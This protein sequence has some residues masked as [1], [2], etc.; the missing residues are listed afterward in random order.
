MI[1]YSAKTL[2]LTLKYMPKLKY[3]VPMMFLM[4][5]HIVYPFELLNSNI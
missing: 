5:F 3:V 1:I 2:I 4:K